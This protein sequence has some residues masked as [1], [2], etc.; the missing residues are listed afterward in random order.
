MNNNIISA[1]LKNKKG[2]TLVELMV[3]VVIIGILAAI[4]VPIYNN[5]SSGSKAKANEANIRAIQGAITAYLANTGGGNYAD[6]TMTNAGAIAGTGITAGNLVPDYIKA[7]PSYP[8]N[9]A[10][11]YTKAAAADVIQE[12]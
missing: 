12:P 3:V 5:V 4:A 9:T 10:K 7:I 2:F 6:V 8:L 1:S 11:K